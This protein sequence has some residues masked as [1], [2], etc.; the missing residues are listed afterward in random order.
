MSQGEIAGL[1]ETHVEADWEIS[2]VDKAAA[3][4]AAK[5]RKG[6]VY[7][8]TFRAKEYDDHVLLIS[9]TGDAEFRTT[10]GGP[11]DGKLYRVTVEEVK[12]ATE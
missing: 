11:L 9:R 4:I 7:E 10:D 12:D 1:I 8:D 5:M 6:V 2:G 3:A